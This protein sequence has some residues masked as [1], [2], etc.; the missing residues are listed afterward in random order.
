MSYAKGASVNVARSLDEI[1][2][3]LR[4]HECFEFGQFSTRE[5]STI[6]FRQDEISYKI[7][8]TIPDPDDK[9]FTLTPSGRFAR[10]KEAA[11]REYQGEVRRRFRSLVLVVKAK[12]I[13]VDEGIVE[14]QDEFLAYA[15][16][17][18]GQTVG[19]FVRPALKETARGQP[20]V[21]ALPGCD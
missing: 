21:L 10:T 8:I 15:I 20:F 18:D 2:S 13:A 6:M 9:A 17:A 19:Q 16:M 1:G 14:F 3:L 5:N 12:L 4:R 7:T 11:D